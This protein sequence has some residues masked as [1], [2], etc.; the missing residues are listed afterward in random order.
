LLADSESFIRRITLL[1]EKV[2]A[3]DRYPFS[4]PAVKHLDSLNLDA[5]VTFLMGEN[6]SGKSTL[7]EAIAVAAGFN[8]EGGTQNFS[9]ATRRSESELHRVLRLVR[10][11][12]RP[13][14]GFFLRAESYFNVAT[15][16]E[17]MDSDPWANALRGPPVIDSFGGTSLHEQSHGESFMALVKHRFGK[18]GLYILDEPE[19]ALSPKRQLELLRSMYELAEQKNC[20]FIVATHSPILL[21]YPKALLYELSAEGIHPTI[22]EA[23]EHYTVTRDFLLNREKH[24]R[25]LL[26][27]Q[28]ELEELEWL[29][30]TRKS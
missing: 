20:Q 10:G 22:Y 23:T 8:A 27:E 2:E 26:G 4:I 3:F 1:R 12:R 13:A 28:E 15:N 14:T 5:K 18:N 24:L 19:A 11:V 25:E 16:I 9:F 7:I 17:E 30:S 21:G 29:R 6:G